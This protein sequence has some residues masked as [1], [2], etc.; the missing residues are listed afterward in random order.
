MRP[1]IDVPYVQLPM[2]MNDF[3]GGRIDFMFD[4]PVTAMPHVKSG[5]VRVLAVSPGAVETE[6]LVT[7]MRARAAAASLTRGMKFVAMNPPSARPTTEFK[8][9]G[10]GATA[11]PVQVTVG[12]WERA[13]NS[14]TSMDS[15]SP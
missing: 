1:K 14:N 5:R 6:R 2:A 3:L 12:G 13:F 11:H 9:T 7:L 4:F 15:R 8:P 10:S